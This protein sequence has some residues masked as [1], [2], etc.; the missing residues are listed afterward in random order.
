MISYQIKYFLVLVALF[1]ASFMTYG[2][3]YE[4]VVRN[5]NNNEPIPNV[6][7]YFANS[8]VGT[9]S[10][11]DGS[12]NINK[13]KNVKGAL[14][15][16][17]MG[18]ELTTLTDLDGTS[19]KTVYLK[20]KADQLDEVIVSGDPMSR[21]DKEGYFLNFFIGTTYFS[22]GV[23]I[24]N[25]EEI[26]L[27]FI[28]SEMVLIAEAPTPILIHHPK[29]GYDIVYDLL[30]FQINFK[31][32][33][34]FGLLE[35]ASPYLPVSGYFEGY[36]FYDDK[37]N[38][39]PENEDIISLRRELYQ[40]SL[41]NFFKGITTGN[42]KEHKFKLKH[43]DKKVEANDHIE[44]IKEDDRIFVTFLHDHYTLKDHK[45]KRSAIQ[46]YDQELVFDQYLNLLNPRD[47]QVSGFLGELGLGGQLPIDY[48]ND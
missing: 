2:Q 44:F 18:F 47:L 6:L 48:V 43:L 26:S 9:V 14:V 46:L 37:S 29:L 42:L 1:L 41:F 17:S 24:E 12:F 7:I 38:D 25:I 10:R 39:L 40:S 31:R 33:E 30:E 22:K 20:E 23:E 36:P 28:P 5:S 32:N 4:G 13:P 34:N 16:R 21:R 45:R 11:M 35:D 3:E 27:K 8:S 19:F 15:F